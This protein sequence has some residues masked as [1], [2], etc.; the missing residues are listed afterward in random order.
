MATVKISAKSDFFNPSEKC[1]LEVCKVGLHDDDDHL[2]RLKFLPGEWLF[3]VWKQKKSRTGLNLENTVDGAAVSSAI[4]PIWPWRRQRCEPVHCHG[5][6]ALFPSPNG[7]VFSAVRRRIGTMIQH[8]KAL[9]PFWP[10]PGSQ[11]YFANN[12]DSITDQKAQIS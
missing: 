12:F 9:W 8:S 3:Q 11:S 7:A 6:Q 1:F 5:G 4:R 10:S 2:T